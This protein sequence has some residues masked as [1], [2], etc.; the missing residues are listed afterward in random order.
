MF[1]KEKKTDGI[2]P[3]CQQKIL[4]KNCWV[5]YHISYDPEMTI[6]ACKYCN[7]C[8][9]LL[10]KNLKIPFKYYKRAS[11]IIKFHDKLDIQ[12]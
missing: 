7:H 2:C 9:Y 12:I 3:I 11:K 5:K 4:G 1:K 8:E 6:L 10:R